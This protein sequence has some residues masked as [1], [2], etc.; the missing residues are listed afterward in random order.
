[1]HYK[2]LIRLLT[3]VIPQLTISKQAARSSHTRQNEALRAIQKSPSNNIVT[4]KGPAGMA[5]NARQDGGLALGLHLT[6]GSRGIRV[7]LVGK[8]FK[9]GVGVMQRMSIEDQDW[10]LGLHAFMD[11]GVVKAGCT[12]LE[13]S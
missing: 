6:G 5:S 9:T 13:Q 1:R 12:T 10:M 3:V 4:H 8:D 7:G 11:F 2:G